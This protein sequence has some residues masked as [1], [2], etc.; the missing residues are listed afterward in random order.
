MKYDYFNLFRYF[1]KEYREKRLT[2]E[3]L[4]EKWKYSQQI[5]GIKP[6]EWRM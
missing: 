5:T 3:Q 4:I 6:V 2:R 1:I